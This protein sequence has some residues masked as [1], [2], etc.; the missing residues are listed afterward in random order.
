[1]N[2][3]QKNQINIV[4]VDDEEMIVDELGFFFEDKG[5]NVN[6]FTDPKDAFEKIEEDGY[7]ILFTDLKMPKLSGMELIE[8]IREIDDEIVIF[9][10]TGFATTDSA[11]EAIQ[12][13]V[14]DYIKKPFD[15]K[16]IAAAVKR[17]SEKILLQRENEALN[18]KVQQM[19]SYITT[20]HDI[21]SIIYQIKNFKTVSTM[22][23][24]T[25]SEGME[26]NSVAILKEN[27]ENQ[28]EFFI[29][30]YTGL[31]SDFA[32]EFK[33]IPD[34]SEI[35]GTIIEE[36]KQIHL[37]NLEKKVSIDGSKISNSDEINRILLTPIQY[38]ESTLGYIGIFNFE[39][40]NF[41][42]K[43]EQHLFNIISTQ[44]VPIFF[45]DE[46]S[47]SNLQ[48][49]LKEQIVST[50]SV[51]INS[52]IKKSQDKNDSLSFAQIRLENVKKYS[53]HFTF[54]KFTQKIE[55]IIKSEIPNVKIIW[56]S[57]DNILVVAR[58]VSSVNFDLNCANI[59]NKIEDIARQD[60]EQ[61][62]FS[63]NYSVAIYPTE[64]RETEEIVEHFR[65]NF[66]IT[67]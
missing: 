2:E 44:M 21:S 9:I 27:S 22:L 36:G 35:N 29:D 6:G 48:E 64:Y 62:V 59:R 63:A 67:E 13:D 8:K 40:D 66:L 16:E 43:D 4:I 41:S 15:F 65:N 18:E 61:P 56:K 38:Q 11:I 46:K 34:N 7:D 28:G 31:D 30:N 52:A 55:S 23:M 10:I 50:D 24:D 26:I 49:I 39:I 33:F 14:Y 57:L 17:A 12:H 42:L 58:N 19:L 1:M 5:Y 45:Q 54:E 51:I 37:D 47:S 25:L 3:K 60:D 20:I 32:D 53:D